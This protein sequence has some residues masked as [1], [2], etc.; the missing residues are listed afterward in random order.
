MVDVAM[1]SFETPATNRR[2]CLGFRTAPAAIR[3]RSISRHDDRDGL[4][5]GGILC[6]PLLPLVLLFMTACP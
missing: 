6:L 2:D 4:S 1:P 5:A 3:Q